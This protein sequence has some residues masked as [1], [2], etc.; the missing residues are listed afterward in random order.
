MKI[1]RAGF[2][3]IAAALVPAAALAATRRYALAT[4]FAV[5]GGFMAC[6]FRDPDREAPADP[7]AVVAF[8][9]PRTIF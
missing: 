6:F 2:P 1:D 7:D 9:P 5:L 4:P 8:A 3:F